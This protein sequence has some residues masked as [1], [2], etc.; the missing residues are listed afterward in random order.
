MFITP[1]DANPQGKINPDSIHSPADVENDAALQICVQDAKN[2]ESWLQSNYWGLRWREADALYQSPPGVMMWEGTTMPRANSNR[3]VVA[4]TVNT[5]HEQIMNGLF[6]E[7]PAFVLRPRPNEDQNTTRAITS[8][9]SIQIDDAHVREE[10]GLGIHSALLFGTGIWKWGYENFKQ[11]VIKYNRVNDEPSI[12]GIDGTDRTLPTPDSMEFEEVEDEEDVFRPTFENMDIRYVLVD[13]GCK[14][15]DIRKAKFVIDRRYL[16]FRDIMKLKDEQYVVRDPKT[17]KKSLKSRY[18]LPSEAEI[19]E[20]FL[21]PSESPAQ[22]DPTV[23]T[24][25]QNNSVIH[26]ATPRFKKTTEDPLN[27]PL[28]VLERWDN[29]KVITVIQ[30]VKCIRNEPN[31]YKCNPFLSINWWNIPDAFWGLGLGRVIGVEQRIQAGLIN[32]CL[33]LANLIVNPMFV[34]SK[35]ANI[36]TQ[37]IRQRI[38][39]IITADG[40]NPHQALTMLEQPSI[41]NEIIQQISMSE[42][43]VEK[44]SGASQAFTSGASTGKAGAAR[45]GTGAAAMINATMSR[46]GATAEV[47]VRQVFEPMLY[48]MHELNKRKTPIAYIKKLLGEKMGEDYAKF[49]PQ[50]FMNAYAVFDVLAGSHLA[51]KAQM[52]QSLF[53]MIQLFETP[54]LL[55]QLQDINGMVVD[56][57]ELFHMV[58]DISGWKNY[59]KVVRP[60]TDQ[61]QQRKQAKDQMNSPAAKAQAQQQ[62]QASQLDGKKQLIDQENNARIVKDMFRDLAKRSAEPQVLNGALPTEGV[63]SQESV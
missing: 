10:T 7:T 18:M 44:A 29:D 6:Y 22:P 1:D 59:Y 48:K 35:G 21:P 56:V 9:L 49:N 15:P 24:S 16:T 31:E 32:A 38:G 61:E 62:V 12:E 4:E 30:R 47:F 51:A 27:E 19:R 39:G 60:M 53:M 20:W 11:T 50:D 40:P 13:P 55:A 17:K 58:H 8:L 37:Q 23:A 63:G 5:I 34:R 3:Y 57:E 52:A 45:S 26:H 33:D 46:I 14:V 54:Q 25:I 41:P 2:T 42:S 28:E 36:E 43:R